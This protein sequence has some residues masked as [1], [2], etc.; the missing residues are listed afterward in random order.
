MYKWM[1]EAHKQKI[2]VIMEVWVEIMNLK[3][4]F[5]VE[6]VDLKEEFSSSN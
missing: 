1:I 5:H 3:K 6:V 2:K 4:N